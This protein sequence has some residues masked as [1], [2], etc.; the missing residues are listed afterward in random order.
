MGG[1]QR[2]YLINVSTASS[3]MRAMPNPQ[4]GY[5]ERLEMPGYA[6]ALPVPYVRASLGG[7]TVAY[8]LDILFILG[9]TAVL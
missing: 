4:T 3:G 8:L 7:R 1:G 5:A 6:S 9:F 2:T